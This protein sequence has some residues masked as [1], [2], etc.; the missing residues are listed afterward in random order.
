MVTKAALCI[1]PLLLAALAGGEALAAGAAGEAVVARW[2]GGEVTQAQ[3]RECL[4]VRRKS[5]VAQGTGPAAARCVDDL[6]ARAVLVARARALGLETG[7]PFLVQR[8]KFLERYLSG[9]V[10][11]QI[12]A[13]VRAA[14]PAAVEAGFQGQRFVDYSW[15]RFPDRAAAARAREQFPPG[16][17]LAKLKPAGS[18][19]GRSE[20]TLGGL[21]P[22]PAIRATLLALPLGTLSQ[23]VEA[24]DGFWLVVQHR[25]VLPSRH[26]TDMAQLTEQRT[27]TGVEAALKALYERQRA[28]SPARLDETLVARLSHDEAAWGD[29]P[30]KIGE[31][32][33]R[34]LYLDKYDRAGSSHVG[35]SEVTRKR[36]WAERTRRNI[37]AVVN[38][39]LL[40]REAARRGIPERP[41]AQGQIR[42]NDER[43]LLLLL[44]EQEV[45][46]KIPV[47]D[48]EVARY[49]AE[50][51][52]DFRT[53]GRI[54][55]KSLRF[56]NRASAEQQLKSTRK[57]PS[58]AE[59]RR[60]VETKAVQGF[61]DPGTMG[62]ADVPG[63]LRETVAKLAVGEAAFVTA[64]GGEALVVWV[65]ERVPTTTR[66][67][68]EARAGIVQ[69]VRA[70]K[71]DQF[72]NR[73]VDEQL[74]GGRVERFPER[75]QGLE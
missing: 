66:T 34:P 55:W 39:N 24:A 56:A 62:E 74:A 22:D 51:A 15:A 45:D 16:G 30:L 47:A 25:V 63:Y 21:K 44:L 3:V 53:S 49:Y 4:E 7:E 19:S 72:R 54:R 75:L 73:Y 28:A 60:L 18:S 33:G 29:Q 38:R 36:A 11:K 1:G 37:D 65:A 5:G 68:E 26:E 59:V 42:A 41:E 8:E 52:A 31:L 64:P 67:L 69:A 40:R 57:E 23:V 9:E 48:A 10:Q 2:R 14:A 35:G 50:H 32:D 43:A 70:G 58:E 20:G 27:R 12:E 6:L 71:R 61:N 46:A 13:E 17:D